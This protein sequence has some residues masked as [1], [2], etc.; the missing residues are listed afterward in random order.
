MTEG[1]ADA[2]KSL[3]DGTRRL[4]TN[5]SPDE[6]YSRE[7]YEASR[8]SMRT[9]CED[10]RPEPEDPSRPLSRRPDRVI[11]QYETSQPSDACCR[12]CCRKLVAA[13]LLRKGRIDRGCGANRDSSRPRQRRL[14]R[15][16]RPSSGQFLVGI[17][18]RMVLASRGT[19]VTVG[20]T[21]RQRLRRPCCAR[22]AARRL[23]P[24]GRPGMSGV[25]RCRD[26][27]PKMDHDDGHELPKS[28]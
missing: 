9:L 3:S 25:P 12:L 6:R 7:I 8:K 2:G 28:P 24:R 21:D 19:A 17:S 5:P 22:R 11:Y 27:R 1:S 13:C 23:P 10:R 26:R 14:A 18:T 4:E 16:S 20:K 15:N